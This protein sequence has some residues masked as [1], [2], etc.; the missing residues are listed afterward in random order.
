MCKSYMKKILKHSKLF[1]RKWC[2]I[3][4]QKEVFKTWGDMNRTHGSLKGLSLAKFEGIETTSND[5]V[6]I[7]SKRT[8]T[9]HSEIKEGGGQIGRAHV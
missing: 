2:N 8:Q 5:N 4:C 1:L 6:K 9:I 3:A 7:F